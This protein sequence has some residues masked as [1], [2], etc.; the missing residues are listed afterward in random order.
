MVLNLS[1]LLWLIAAFHLP[2]PVIKDGRLLSDF[3]MKELQAAFQAKIARVLIKVE[4]G[5][6]K[7]SLA[8]QIANWALADD[9]S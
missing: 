2:R 1:R 7:T 4:G 8:C 9:P 6:G 5:A 3:G